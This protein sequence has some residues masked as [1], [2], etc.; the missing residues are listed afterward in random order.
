MAKKSK[1]KAEVSLEDFKNRLH[2]TDLNAF[3]IFGAIVLVLGI[4]LLALYS[5]NKNNPDA[6][7][8]GGGRVV[9]A[10]DGPTMRSNVALSL[11]Q[12]TNYLVINPEWNKLIESI[13][14]PYAGMLIPSSQMA[15]FVAGLGEDAVIAGSI[16]P[17]AYDV[18]TKS[19]IRAYGGYQGKVKEALSLYR[20]ARFSIDGGIKVVNQN[21]RM[22]QPI[23][24]Q[25][26][27]MQQP[28]APMQNP[29]LQGFANASPQLGPPTQSFPMMQQQN[30]MMANDMNLDRK[31]FFCPTCGWKLRVENNNVWPNPRC[32]LCGTTMQNQLRPM[33]NNQ[34]RQEPMNQNRGMQ[35]IAMGG[36]PTVG[37]NQR[38]PHGWRGACQNCHQFRDGPCAAGSPGAQTSS[39]MNMV[40]M[41]NMALRGAPTISCN[42]RMPH[43][44]RGACQN[45]HQFRDGPCPAGSPGAQTSQAGINAGMMDI[46][47][48]RRMQ[49]ENLGGNMQ[50]IALGGAP[51]ITCHSIMPHGWRGNCSNCH[52]I[53]DAP[54][55]TGTP[56]AQMTGNRGQMTVAQTL[57]IMERQERRRANEAQMQNVGFLSDLFGGA[58]GGLPTINCNTPMPHG[59]RGKCATC[60][61]V[62]GQPCAASST[63]AKT[64]A[65]MR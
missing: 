15:Y 20:Q 48:N 17:E 41:Q 52:Q 22:N 38:M 10:A 11:A 32:S 4:G 46:N 25:P 27:P 42:K 35:N 23:M 36:A 21:R 62:N 63:V 9:V 6:N 30:A 29:L 47:Q 40:A 49:A 39:N 16:N 5:P 28:I 3:Y 7:T 58:G 45:C 43:G 24:I 61:Q 37:C 51:I 19:G 59:W 33:N 60:H 2:T 56:V 26:Q 50:N 18:L 44:W 14:N 31:N 64:E 54:C 1:N 53:L 8:V 34:N 55:A 65:S 57:P 12:A 13:K